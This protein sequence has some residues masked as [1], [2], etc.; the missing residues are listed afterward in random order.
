MFVCENA[1][2]FI[3]KLQSQFHPDHFPQNLEHLHNSCAEPIAPPELDLMVDSTA[4]RCSSATSLT[5]NWLP[6]SHRNLVRIPN[7][8]L[9]YCAVLQAPSIF[10]FPAPPAPSWTTLVHSAEWAAA[11][12]LPLMLLWGTDWMGAFVS[13]FHIHFSLL[14]FLGLEICICAIFQSFSI[15]KYGRRWG[16][17]SGG[18]APF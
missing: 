13:S 6:E 3:F 4:L 11:A 14:C 2:S 8:M 18:S 17:V 10:Y 1:F 9:T 5:H 16:H 12:N 15:L 7:N